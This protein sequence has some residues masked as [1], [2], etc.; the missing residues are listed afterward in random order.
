MV[1]RTFYDEIKDLNENNYQNFINKYGYIADIEFAKQCLCVNSDAWHV[2]SQKLKNNSDIIMYYQPRGYLYEEHSSINALANNYSEGY[3]W[4]FNEGFEAY[5]PLVHCYT[6][7][8]YSSFDKSKSENSPFQY[9][10][11]DLPDNF[12]LNKYYKIQAELISQKSNNCYPIG[13]LIENKQFLNIIPKEY[14]HL[15]YN[16]E[17]IKNTLIRYY[18]FDRSKLKEIV[19]SITEKQSDAKQKKLVA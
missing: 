12:D 10:A 17:E 18:L 2:L 5:F 11:I 3:L 14:R 7:S 19:E 1:V 4:S 15:P 13:S 6:S 9:P 16:R 8:G